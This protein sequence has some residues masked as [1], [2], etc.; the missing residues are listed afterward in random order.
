MD[1]DTIVKSF[2]KN[3]EHLFLITTQ[4]MFQHNTVVLC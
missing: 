3:I 1:R 2:A 4:I